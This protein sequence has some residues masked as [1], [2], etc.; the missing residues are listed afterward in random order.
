MRNKEQWMH[1]IRCYWRTDDLEAVAEVADAL[2]AAE[3]RGEPS[4]IWHEVA[5]WVWDNIKRNRCSICDG[6]DW[7]RN[8]NP[9]TGAHELCRQRQK[10]GVPTPPLNAKFECHCARCEREGTAP[11]YGA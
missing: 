5:V 3:E 4:C 11:K 8:L 10:R 6:K 9:E 7:G 1:D 2:I